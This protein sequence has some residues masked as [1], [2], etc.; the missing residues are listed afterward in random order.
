M[1]MVDR[2]RVA[3]AA[4]SSTYARVLVVHPT[5]VT[6]VSVALSQDR[7][8]IRAC[9]NAAEAPK[10]IDE[11]GPHLVV[12]D[13]DD[14]TDEVDRPGG[15][16]QLPD[17]VP[18]I[19]LTGR[20][21]L[22]VKL[23]AFRR[24]LDDVVCS[25]VAPEE[26]AARVWAVIGRSRRQAAGLGA[27]LTIGALQIDFL[28]RRVRAG[29]RE[30][31]L[32]SLEQSLLFLLATNAGRLL[33]R[34]EILDHLWGDDF[35][36]ESNVVDGHVRNLRAKLRD[37]WRNPRYIITVAGLGYRFAAPPWTPPASRFGS[38]VIAGIAALVVALSS[39]AELVVLALRSA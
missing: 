4:P 14:E 31:H 29:N 8:V 11:W 19:G 38:Q 26:L 13:L 3:E 28:R 34:N 1:S 10:V 37:D 6:P 27:A 33:T 18:S 35:V 9:R 32:T 16:P 36:P 20:S 39:P 23:A 2:A 24:G 5:I 21:D 12:I 7:A 17:H 25:P 15:A 30:L 22:P